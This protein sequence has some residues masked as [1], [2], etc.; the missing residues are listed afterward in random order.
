MTKLGDQAQRHAQVIASRLRQAYLAPS[1]HVTTAGSAGI[2]HVRVIAIYHAQAF[3]DADREHA[4]PDVVF[5]STP[6]FHGA[7]RI[8]DWK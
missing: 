7:L 3:L 1:H 8:V 5:F 4:G 6:P 2:M